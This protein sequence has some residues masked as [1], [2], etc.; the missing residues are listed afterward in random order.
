MKSNNFYTINYN[1]AGS[2]IGIY[3]YIN[4][5]LEN[6]F[7]DSTTIPTIERNSNCLGKSN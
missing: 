3:T 4:A 6:S 2:S 5:V 7:T 1:N